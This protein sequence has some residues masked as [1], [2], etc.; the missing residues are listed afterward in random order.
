M[1]RPGGVDVVYRESR[2]Y[3][4]VVDTSLFLLYSLPG[5]LALIL[6]GIGL[7]GLVE[8]FRRHSNV[9][10]RATRG[11]AYIAVGLGLI[12]LVGVAVLFDPVFTAGRVFG[13]LSLAIAV[14]LTAAAAPRGNAGGTWVVTLMLVGAIGVFLLPVWPLVYAL[15]CLSEAAGA[16]SIAL[17]GA[18]W[19]VVGWRLWGDAALGDR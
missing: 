4:V 1:L 6:T 2:G 15:G 7:L 18:G 12:S 8:H 17:F 11:F 13:T 9:R 14:I 5:S 10:S 3:S 19:I 16:L